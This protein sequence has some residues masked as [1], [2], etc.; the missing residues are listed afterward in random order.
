[1]QRLVMVQRADR[2]EHTPE[3]EPLLIDT[4]APGVL[5]L[6]L[7]DGVE[8]VG[9]CAAFAEAGVVVVSTGMREAA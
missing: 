2:P 3:A 6:V 1:M 9:E 5:R 7:D 4:D 8:I